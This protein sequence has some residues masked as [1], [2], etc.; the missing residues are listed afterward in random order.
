MNLK[1]IKEQREV[2]LDNHFETESLFNDL[3]TVVKMVNGTP[4]SEILDIS[5]TTREKYLT[6]TLTYI[7][8]Y[9]E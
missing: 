3:M 7:I 6:L 9:E 2:E 8:G 4:D 1:R 5:L